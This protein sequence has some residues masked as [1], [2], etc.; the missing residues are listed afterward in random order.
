MIKSGINIAD[1]T[2]NIMNMKSKK[3]KEVSA[4]YLRV[5]GYKE[6]DGVWAA[7]CLETDLVGYGKT[8]NKALDNLI[9]LTGM[10]ID[11]AKF[12]NQP[13]LLDRPAPTE[14]VETYNLL[15]R[16]NLQSITNPKKIDR[17]RKITS[18][19]LPGDLSGSEFTVVP[20]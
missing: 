8:F 13:S 14:I 6:T 15:M 7:H 3:T 11:F 19:P 4:L 18:I 1:K 20:S 16:S 2:Y 9:E 12:K 17:S 5:L 10:Q